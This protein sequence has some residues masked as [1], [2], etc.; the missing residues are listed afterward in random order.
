MVDD[1]RDVL[2]ISSSITES[3]KHFMKNDKYDF[4]L[5][6]QELQM[7]VNE[8]NRFPTFLST[9]FEETLLAEGLVILRG[10]EDK[11]SQAQKEDISKI[12]CVRSIYKKEKDEK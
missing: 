2:K 9:N 1:D 4:N 8:H 7:F 5:I 12:F 6:I 3:Y 10:H 11:L